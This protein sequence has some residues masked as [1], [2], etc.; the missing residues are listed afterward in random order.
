MTGMRGNGSTL[1]VSTGTKHE[2]RS[3]KPGSAASGFRLPAS[4]C[5]SREGQV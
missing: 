3:M 5:A 2:A 4:G 1:V